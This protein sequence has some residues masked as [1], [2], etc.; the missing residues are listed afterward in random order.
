VANSM[1][2]Q[3]GPSRDSQDAYL[4]AWLNT[5]S[6]SPKRCLFLEFGWTHSAAHRATCHTGEYLPAPSFSRSS[7]IDSK[8]CFSSSSSLTLDPKPHVR[9]RD[10]RA[11]WDA[12]I[13]FL[14]E[15]PEAIVGV[16]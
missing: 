1:P 6:I 14:G 12:S 13:D 8:K 11:K 2:P 15:S 7:S 5:K 10:Y 9:L 3:G 4:T 16:L